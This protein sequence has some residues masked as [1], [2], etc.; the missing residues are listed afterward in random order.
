MGLWWSGERYSGY[1]NT[2]QEAVNSLEACLN[3][4]FG[5]GLRTDREV[6]RVYFPYRGQKYWIHL[7]RSGHSHW[8]YIE[9]YH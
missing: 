8:V 6:D 7:R 9:L 3:F 1:G 5:R 2:A 4:H